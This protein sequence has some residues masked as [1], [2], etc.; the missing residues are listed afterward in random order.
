[1]K[2]LILVRHGKSSW[3]HDVID[4]E[5]PL[6]N[7]GFE[8]GRKVAEA[9][10]DAHDNPDFMW[11]SDAKRAH[12]TAII[13]KEN[14][15]FDDNKFIVKSKLYTFD[16]RD[17]FQIIKGC[18]DSVNSLMVFG[19]NHAMTYVANNLGDQYIDNVPTTGLV[20]IDF[21]VERWTQ[22]KKGKTVNTLFPKDLK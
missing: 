22:I 17:L 6:K 19:H 20:I 13:F 2:R 11:T 3:E 7:R 21:D 1:M 8:D 15:L 4:H 12:T 16:D 14:L 18:E 5:R 9:Y 10:K